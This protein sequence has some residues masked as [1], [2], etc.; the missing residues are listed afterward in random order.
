MT[1]ELLRDF[2]SHGVRYAVY[3]DSFHERMN[4][5]ASV[6]GMSNAIFLPL[7][8]AERMARDLLDLVEKAKNGN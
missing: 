5:T 8:E 4:I 6:H 2:I 3:W 7:E 1:I